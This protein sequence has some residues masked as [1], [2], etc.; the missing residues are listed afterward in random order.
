[1][2]SANL[3]TQICDYVTMFLCMIAFITSLRVANDLFN[4]GEPNTN[5]YV[6]SG[7]AIWYPIKMSM[8]SAL[9][10][11][12]EL[13]IMQNISAWLVILLLIKLTLE[14]SKELRLLHNW[15]GIDR[16]KQIKG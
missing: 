8:I 9:N 15:H 11:N 16:R 7:L 3:V 1:M 4:Q 14:K 5:Y 13:M 10:T 12:Y 2:I 6:M